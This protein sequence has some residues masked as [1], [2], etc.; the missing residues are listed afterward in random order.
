MSERDWSL[1]RE[2]DRIRINSVL[3]FG[4]DVEVGD[5]GE[6]HAISHWKIGGIRH[7]TMDKGIEISLIPGEDEWD[8]L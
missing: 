6:I 7:V 3:M 4:G 1:G 5:E 8:V 2:G